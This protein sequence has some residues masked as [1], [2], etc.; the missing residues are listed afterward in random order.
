[1]GS[2]VFILFIKQLYKPLVGS[3]AYT[4]KSF[5]WHLQLQAHC[6]GTLQTACA[7]THTHTAAPATLH[8][9]AGAPVPPWLYSHVQ[10]FDISCPMMATDGCHQ[11]LVH[12][13]HVSNHAFLCKF[14]GTVVK[15][16][17]GNTNMRFKFPLCN[18]NYNINTGIN[19]QKYISYVILSVYIN[20]VS[21]NKFIGIFHKNAGWE[22]H[23]E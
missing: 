9:S 10:R 11:M 6:T 18:K 1:M 4:S 3:S 13:N 19:S 16:L 5:H 21:I 23:H 22:H 12:T 2:I 8:G 20:W 15:T 17:D 7:H 14:W